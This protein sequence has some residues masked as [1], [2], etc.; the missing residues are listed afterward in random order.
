MSLP[1]CL[2]ATLH[3]SPDLACSH[4]ASSWTGFIRCTTP[5]TP[6]PPS[7]W[8]RSRT[9]A[10]R[11]CLSSCCT[12]G[13]RASG[14]SLPL[15]PSRP[16]MLTMG[17]ATASSLW[18]PHHPSVMC[19]ATQRL[20]LTLPCTCIPLSALLHLITLPCLPL[21]L[22][23]VDALLHSLPCS[24]HGAIPSCLCWLAMACP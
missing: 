9:P 11:T 6:C 4:A 20:D 21:R 3:S 8:S 16:C 13:C 17:H 22:V 1:V 23:D 12:G 18:L 19:H 7:P 10:T 24:C 5:S 14:A 2:R 15:H